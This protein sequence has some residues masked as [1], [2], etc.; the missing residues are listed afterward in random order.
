M[1]HRRRV[2]TA[3]PAV[4][5]VKDVAE[6]AGVSTATVSRVLS[7]VSAVREPRRTKV[8]EAA[9]LLRYRPNRAARD[10]RARSSRAIGVLIPDIEN[11]F[12]TSAVCGIEEVLQ[13]AGY[14]LLLASYNENPTRE[15]ELLNTFRAEGVAGLI[16]AASRAPSTIYQ[17]LSRAGLAMVAI[18][19][20]PGK[21]RTDQV[22]V[23][24]RA[25]AMTATTHLLQHGH[26]RLA[27]INGPAALSTARERQQ[28]Y[29]QALS[30]YGLPIDQNLIK[31]GD[32][33]QQ[34]GYAAMQE[35]LRLDVRPTAVFTAS[36]LLTLGALQA[37][38]EEGLKVPEEIAM[39]GFDEMAWS[40]SLR[41]PLTTIAQPS[42]AVGRTAATMLLERLARPD[43]PR[44]QISLETHLIIRASSGGSL[45][46]HA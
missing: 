11:P 26:V 6:M 33:R 17:Q 1:P 4:A 23:A 15:G 43:L 25:G 41:P 24:N 27:L 12:F 7:G 34:A 29:E 13:S 39:V 5:T 3:P 16:F 44:R 19:R 31:Q 40:I 46:L 10:I 45:K 36:N 32:F 9:R 22:T 38:H 8:L 2:Q 28:G 30:G 20:V 18:S 21:L 14:S 35:L 42:L 37:I